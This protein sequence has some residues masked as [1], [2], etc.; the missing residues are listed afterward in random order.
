MTLKHAAWLLLAPAMAAGIACAQDGLEAGFQA[1]TSTAADLDSYY[2]AIAGTTPGDVWRE[3]ASRSPIGTQTVGEAVRLAE[4]PYGSL[5]APLREAIARFEYM[6]GQGDAVTDIALIGPTDWQGR[7]EVAGAVISTLARDQLL[8]A[9]AAAADL[10]RERFRAAVVTPE[11]ALSAADVAS[12]ADFA[13]AGGTIVAVRSL[14]NVPGVADLFG[15]EPGAEVNEDVK[16]K[17]SVHFVPRDMNRLVP[18]LRGLAD[19]VFLYPA[20]REIL[21]DH[22]RLGDTDWYILRN[23]G[24]TGFDTYATFRCTGAPQFWDCET[25]RILPDQGYERL[26]EGKTIVPVR[27]RGNSATCV[28]FRQQPQPWHVRRAP[29]LEVLSLVKKAEAVTVRALA[30]MNGSYTI[31]LQDGRKQVIE[32]RDLPPELILDGTWQLTT[33]Q[34]IQRQPAQVVSARVKVPSAEDD[35]SK[36]ALPDYDDT[37]WAEM[38]FGGALPTEA[39]PVEWHASWL[40]F[41]GDNATR[42][43]R[44][45]FDLPEPVKRGTITITADNAY[46]LFVNGQR[47]G[48]DGT[49]Q[50][51]ETYPVIQQLKQGPNVIAVRATN[52]GGIAGLLAEARV[53][54]QSGKE[55]LV[56]TDGDWKMATQA[57][58]DWQ[59]PGYDD[60]G[61]GKPQVLGAAPMAPWGNVPGLPAS[62][63]EAAIWYR[64]PLPPGAQKLRLPDGTGPRTLYVAGKAVE[65]LNNEAE[66]PPRASGAAAL[67]VAGEAVP[68]PITVECSADA[69]GVGSWAEQGFAD[70]AGKATYSRTLNLPQEYRRERLVL[71]LGDVG[72]A[73]AVTLNDRNVGVRLWPPYRLELPP[74][75][76]GANDLKIVVANTVATMRD[77]QNAPESGLLGPVTLIPLRELTVTVP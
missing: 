64:F 1:A 67:R 11:A 37:T 66:I 53:T 61:W 55:V 56:V 72:V 45:A 5:L 18:L 70:Y 26:D 62:A 19:D 4:Q 22:R 33:D 34:P 50:E 8:F 58:G 27:L 28:V 42:F 46:E 71:D 29:G 7:P 57:E 21:A 13:N 16:S 23:L 75:R 30:S 63:G 6:A 14:P 54:L 65:I 59:A 17:G 60:A 39:A 25:G 36:W 10:S 47:V 74:L 76:R 2:P 68:G 44:R 9:P 31:E 41:E 24:P 43:F 49:W 35:T 51:A 52:E 32:V 69:I 77:P 38:E 12:L 3:A 40:G 73:A 15:V 48:A 20:S